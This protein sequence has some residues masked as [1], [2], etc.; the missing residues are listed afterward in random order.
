[1]NIRTTEKVEILKSSLSIPSC[2]ALLLILTV[3]FYFAAV[4]SSEAAKKTAP[5]IVVYTTEPWLTNMSKFIVGT[6]VNV[7]PLSTWSESGN[8][9]PLRRAPI[10]SVV[11]AV[12]SVDAARYGLKPVRRNLYM[13]YEQLPVKSE[14]RDMLAFDPSVLPFF[15]QRLLVILSALNADNYSYYQRRL[16]EFQSRMESTLEVGRSLLLDVKM[17]DLT[18]ASSPWIRAAAKGAVRP[19]EE[20]WGSWSRGEKMPE[21]SVVLNEAKSRSWWIVIDTRTPQKIRAAVLGAYKNIYIKPP[22]KEQDF[23]TYMHDIYLELW[24][25]MQKEQR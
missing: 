2:R 20:L 17:L 18:G 14:N 8:I 25:A 13:L 11:I 15:S 19:P 16:A 5:S 9:V 1:M 23:F 3:I 4:G 10:G 21:L 22:S 12:D 6:T 7:Q 24:S